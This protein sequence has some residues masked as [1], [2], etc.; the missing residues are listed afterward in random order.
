MGVLVLT[1]VLV[2]ST[3][4]VSVDIL[5]VMGRRCVAF[6]V[7]VLFVVGFGMV[8]FVQVG[9]SGLPLI[10]SVLIT[11]L[12][13]MIDIVIASVLPS[14]VI[15]MVIDVFFLMVPIS[16]LIGLNLRGR[17]FREIVLVMESV[18]TMRVLSTMV[19]VHA[20]GLV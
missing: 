14:V 2:T 10:I 18:E 4:V 8:L 19:K 17:V 6:I 15:V 7:T 11:I 16:F 5:I 12:V 3:T 9:M 20:E 1:R 13:V